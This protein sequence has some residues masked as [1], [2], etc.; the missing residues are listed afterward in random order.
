MMLE[1]VDVQ[2]HSCGADPMLV[3]SKGFS[4]IGLTD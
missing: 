4:S 3:R 1:N 2:P